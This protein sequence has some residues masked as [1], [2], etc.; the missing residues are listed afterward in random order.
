MTTNELIAEIEEA[1][2]REK[3]EKAAKEYGPYVLAGCL[4]AILFTGLSAGWHSWQTRTNA[5]H[6]ATILAA[7]E[8]PDAPRQLADA[9]ARL[10]GG[11]T[12]VARLAAAGLYLQQDK[13]PEALEQ[14]TLAAA[15]KGGPDILHDMARLQ[16]IRLEWDI[17]GGKADPKAMLDSLAPLL[18]DKDNPWHAHAQVQA[19]LIT[20]HGLGDLQAARRHLAG[21]I[22]RKDGL[23]ESVVVRARSLD[24]IYSLKLGDKADAAPAKTETQG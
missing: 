1:V 19:A 10:G 21:V 2:R 23:P 14:F 22:A 5:A 4:L 15:D 16:A 12:L 17:T 18:A 20:A 11:Q 8:K 24:H 9:A 6:T 3:L 7:V 13:K